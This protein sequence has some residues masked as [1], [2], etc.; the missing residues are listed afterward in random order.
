MQDPTQDSPFLKPE[1]VDWLEKSGAEELDSDQQAL[2]LAF[3]QLESE[4]GQDL[5]QAEKEALNAMGEQ[6]SDADSQ[7]IVDA[8]RKVVNAPS[9][10]ERAIS[11]SEL[12]RRSE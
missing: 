11:W 6:M 10:P 1:K 8:V 12:E 5:S 2:L 7:E 9:D 4:L 3:A